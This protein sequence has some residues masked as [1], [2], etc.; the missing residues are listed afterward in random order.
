M[1]NNKWNDGDYG[2]KLTIFEDGLEVKH[3]GPYGKIKQWN[4]F[5][6]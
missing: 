2:P 5:L 1:K 6:I 4:L 3:T